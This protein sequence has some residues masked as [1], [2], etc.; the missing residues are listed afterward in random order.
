[1]QENQNYLVKLNLLVEEDYGKI[2]KVKEQ[3]LVK[4]ASVSDAETKINKEFEGENFEV[5]SVTESKI[6]K[7][8]N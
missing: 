3:Y 5:V 2:K 7:Y 8:I 1:M 4:A 6:I